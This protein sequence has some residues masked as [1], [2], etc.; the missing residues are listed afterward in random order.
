MNAR[1][2]SKSTTKDNHTSWAQPNS[3]PQY[4]ERESEEPDQRFT[5]ILTPHFGKG[6][7]DI[8]DGN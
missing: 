4:K 7:Y 8:I 5:L 3:W 1:L 2:I 6:F